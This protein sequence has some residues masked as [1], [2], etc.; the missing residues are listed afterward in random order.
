MD[1]IP[2]EHH[3]SGVYT[4]LLM[5]FLVETMPSDQI[6]ELLRRAGESRGLEELA[7]ASSWSS[8]LQFK[9]LLEE[10]SRLDATSLYEQS[11]LLSDWLR[12]W[13]LSQAAQTLDSPGTLLASGSDLNPLVPIRRYDKTEVAPNEWTIREWFEPGYA[14]FP[15][16][17]DFAAV[18]YALVPVVFNLPPGE[19]IEEE[20]QC[21]GDA[22][23]L[24][25]LRWQHHDTELLRADHYRMRAELF[26]ARLEQIQDMIAD[27]ASTERYEDVLQGF[28]SSSL[29]TAV[30]AGGALLALESRA[31]T[32]RR[33]FSEGLTAS[34]ADS[35]ADDLLAGRAAPD[36]VVAV[37][38]SSARCSYGVL[39][40]DEGGGVFSSLS[41]E[42][43]RDVRPVGGGRPGH[44]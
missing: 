19:V 21:R 9:R 4:K 43:P 35:I 5:E 30:G 12:T 40:V 1:A 15:E 27:L 6:E 31:G 13:E 41:T 44:G 7:D 39:A 37:E 33:V 29:R 32:P 14:P 28:V 20:C 22:T 25:R 23:C 18:Q 3:I 36:Q 42:H 38:V 24:F 10:R 26:E 17:C 11:E 2:A 34:E 16:F 8:Y